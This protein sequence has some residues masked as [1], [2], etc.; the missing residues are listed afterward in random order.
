MVVKAECES[1]LNPS[2]NILRAVTLW[3]SAD[4]F[5]WVY[6]WVGKTLENEF[7][8]CNNFSK[9]VFRLYDIKVTAELLQVWLILD[10]QQ[11]IWSDSYQTLKFSFRIIKI[12]FQEFSSVR[13]F[14]KSFH[15]EL[16]DSCSIDHT[17]R[18]SSQMQ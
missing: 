14:K 17:Q 11:I 15:E 2:P 6:Y 13:H 3:F 12:Q 7:G 9:D 4:S 16:C 18:T 5:Q 10:L 8:F 1:L